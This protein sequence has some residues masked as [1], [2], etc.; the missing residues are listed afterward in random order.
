MSKRIVPGL[1]KTRLAFLIGAIGIASAAVQA[2]DNP[3]GSD[4][5]HRGKM[6]DN[7]RSYASGV[8][9]SSEREA[10]E[11]GG[12]ASSGLSVAER[13]IMLETP[14][15][16]SKSQ[17]SVVIEDQLDGG[18]FD[19]GRAAL[20]PH[21]KQI[22][23]DLA[24][25]LRGKQKIRFQI[26][27]HT[28]NQR[29]SA[30]LRR[31]YPDNQALSEAR[32][33]AVAGYLKEKLNL[34]ADAF[35]VSGRGDTL[36]VADNDTP[37]G[38]AKNRR[39]RL[40]IWY[41]EAAEAP[42]P[43]PAPKQVERM[44]TR[45]A[46]APD[47]QQKG[48][49]FS[50]SVD[51]QP[52]ETDSTQVEADR[53]RCVDV[54]LEKSD[55]QIK[56]DPLNDAPALNAWTVPGVAKRGKPVEFATYT[57]YA[58][59][60][61]KAEVRIF[62]KRQNLQETPFAVVPVDVGG[63]A[64][65]EAPGNAPD[66]LVFVLRVYDR[67]GR[68]DETAPKP[69]RLLDR[70]PADAM[71]ERTAKDRL[72]G[73]GENTLKVRNIPASGGS[74]TISGENIK[75]GQ[76]VR[77]MD[78]D[79]PVDAK[80]KFVMRQILPA[81]PH[82]VSVSVKD[83][84]GEG[85]TFSR[86]LSIADRDWF[87]VAVADLTVGQ[88][89]TTGPAQLVTG[90]TQHYDN[91]T[92]VDGRGA[93]YLKGKIK[94]EYL[95]TASADT[96]EQ[97]LHDL[98]SNFSSK[99]PR[100][101]LRR[102]DPDTYYPVYGDDSTIADDAPTQGKFYVR[103]E[104][105]DS[106][107][108]WGNFQTAW[109]GSEL[110]Q[111]SRGLYG[112]DVMWRSAD[113][114]SFGEKSTS[115][116][117][118]AAEPGTL[119]SREEFR[120]T[121]GSLYYLRQQDITQGSERLWLEVRD[122]DSGLVIQRTQLTPALDYDINYLQGRLTLRAPLSSVADG[123]SLV[124]TSGLSGNPVYLVATYEY[125][126]GLTAV[127]GGTVGVR[128][129]HWINDAVRLGATSYH[130][131]EG[132]ADQDLKGVDATLRYK[133]GT[134]IRAE[135]ARSSGK[136]TTT[137]T[138]VTGGF[139]FNQIASSGKPANAKRVDMAVDLGEIGSGMK[140]RFSAY[141]QDRDAGF[142][143][144]GQV[145]AGTEGLRQEGIAAAVPVND[146]TEVLLKVDNRVATSQTDRSTEAAVR[147]KLAPEWG[148][149]TGM[150]RDDRELA[151]ADSTL[152]LTASPLLNQ[153]GTRS[154]AVV[155]VDFMP[156]AE[157][158]AERAAGKG[159]GSTTAN[160]PAL[161]TSTA[162]ANGP[163]SQLLPKAN[164]TTNTG[165]MRASADPAS[166]AG[167]AGARMPG[168]RYAPWNMYGF[169]QH[170]L[171]RTGTRADND[172]VGLGSGW[173]V[174][175]KLR[176]G[177][178]VSGGSGGAGGQLSGNYRT[179]ERSDIYLAYTMETENPNVNYVGRQ[180]T[181]TAG[182]HYRLSD[183]VGLFGESRWSNGAGPQSLTHAFGV[184]FAPDKQW[185]TGIKLETGSLS[186]PLA[187]DLKR[188]AVGLSASYR[189]DKTRFA[190]A[191]E[192]RF[193]RTTT[194][195]AASG[196]CATP[197]T[198]PDAINSRRSWLTKNSLG[199]QADPS[200]RLLGKLNLSRS[201]STQGAFFD[202]D[203]TEVVLGAAYRPVNDD[204]WNALFKYTY[205]YNVPSP[206]QVDGTF[207]LPLDYAQRSHVLDADVIRDVRPWLSVGAK[208]GVR[209]GDLRPSKTEGDWFS[210]RADLFVLRADFHWVRQ[211]DALV[212]GRALRSREADDMRSGFLAGI[213]R[214]VAQGAKI[215]VGYNFTNFSDDL[216]D[217][218]YRSRGW[219]LN[220]LGTF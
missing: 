93:F 43:A 141:W 32:A 104:K 166:A 155:R 173:Q 210:S 96:R 192:Y 23:D 79:V 137:L 144:P 75:P 146:S 66:E 59:W 91:K 24:A 161:A 85:E 44:V 13:K 170:T 134:W 160:A 168:L 46:C 8:P 11:F 200:W 50:I 132:D 62:G 87:Y 33:L 184:D 194:A 20:L 204:R 147:H 102:I 199:Y 167:I 165:G 113:A 19:S 65:W 219:F 92:W 188:D 27:G 213:Y 3:Q 140:G 183:Q 131:G 99:D 177:A 203:Y 171:S 129:S 29:I 125:V 186:D 217:L 86:N 130:Q 112:A 121:G 78:I 18:I 193:D 163:A 118:F 39:T 70:A 90:D 77:A 98:F 105:D 157:G 133:P 176:L 107:V 115:L 37:E 114:T 25:R 110:T 127:T 40:R 145:V 72:I 195:A 151:S 21:A 69:M 136:G 185:T 89:H 82:T 142:S 205:F 6:I 30:A 45:D 189:Y 207:G 117:L 51:G 53:Q 152:G 197:C 12:L 57:N 60:L 150:R 169:L 159:Q 47:A 181:V 52:L 116:N 143:G 120:G 139:D 111:Y 38:M 198:S 126:P 191:L 202:G 17:Q 5:N 67:Q 22:L 16:E 178:E 49:P 1:R 84:H 31:T 201:I 42:A 41:E 164:P 209:W 9:S 174:N 74:V 2:Q 100:Y 182:S 153:T 36:P 190:T 187:G 148:I 196:A 4:R 35:A 123:G 55:I 154:D 48:L 211:W 101:L 94:G 71:A 7:S 149:S 206:G 106:H 179:S 214:H 212:E 216:T 95:L 15:P 83:E 28:D 68:F 58:W 175:D 56:Y 103:L 119:Q 135:A 63:T 220:A 215:G 109:S 218:S 122:K 81:G 128:A 172:R 108:M 162:S 97:P 180:G 80:G 158:E 124:Q 88:D 54:A 138:S 61:R 64:R 34:S 26:V 10:P 156:L 76:T 14:P 73:Y 208:Y